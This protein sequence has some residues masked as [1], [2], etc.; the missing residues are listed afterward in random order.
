M[1]FN[2]YLFETKNS[3]SSWKSSPI[4]SPSR[5][6]WRNKKEKR[7]RNINDNFPSR[8]IKKPR[9][10]ISLEA[11]AR[12]RKRRG[13]RRR[14]RRRSTDKM[15]AEPACIIRADDASSYF[16][17][18]VSSTSGFKVS[19][20]TACRPGF[21]SMGEPSSVQRTEGDVESRPGRFSGDR[22]AIRGMERPG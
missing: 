22:V 19:F 16:P 3:L 17:S 12:R 9:D 11:Q 7:R 2:F 21:V 5:S 8:G 1:N 14:R 15:E 20:T 18:Y 13:G 6:P 10:A 4:H